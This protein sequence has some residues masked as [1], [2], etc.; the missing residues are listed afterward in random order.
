MSTANAGYID[1]DNTIIS[2]KG[3]VYKA[4]RS[5][6]LQGCYER[7]IAFVNEVDQ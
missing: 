5:V 7:E 2:Q 1:K 6:F 3:Y 4:K